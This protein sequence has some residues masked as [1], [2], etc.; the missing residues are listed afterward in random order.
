V[1]D[2]ITSMDEDFAKWYTDI[3]KKAELIEYTSVKGLHGYPPLRLRNLGEYT[4]DSGRY[5]QGRGA[6]KRVHADVHSRKPAAKGKGHVEALHPNARGL[7]TA[8]TKSLRSALRA[9]TSEPF[10]RAF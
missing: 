7:P 3:C 6:R 4:E 8:A 2:D 5:V 9:P 10:L 1:V